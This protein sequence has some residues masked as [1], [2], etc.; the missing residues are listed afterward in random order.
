M[1]E[2]H[3]LG[4]VTV[5]DAHLAG[6]VGESDD[7][8]VEDVPARDRNLVGLVDFA[9]AAEVEHQP[10]VLPLLLVGILGGEAPRRLTPD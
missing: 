10:I 3:T 5:H 9:A 1:A 4:T 8:I 6:L 7:G 2:N